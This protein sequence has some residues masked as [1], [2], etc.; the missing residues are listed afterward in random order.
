M[1]WA[2]GSARIE[3][4]TLSSC[5]NFWALRWARSANIETMS[6]VFDLMVVL[7]GGDQKMFDVVCG[8]PLI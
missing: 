8:K 2:M 6:I 4:R 7:Y 1:S 5:C 3:L